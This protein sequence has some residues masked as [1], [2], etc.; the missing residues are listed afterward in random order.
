MTVITVFSNIIMT[1]KK[2]HSLSFKSNYYFLTSFFN[3]LDQFNKLKPQKEEIKEKKQMCMIQPENYILICYKY[4]FMN[5]KLFL[6]LR[7]KVE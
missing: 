4:I 6:I 7:K 2:I 5:T 1:L 3:D